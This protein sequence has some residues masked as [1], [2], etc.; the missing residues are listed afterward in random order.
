MNFFISLLLLLVP[1][2][3]YAQI[4]LQ[5]DLKWSEQPVVYNDA[6]GN[7]QWKMWTCS[8]AYHDIDTPTL[9]YLSRQVKVPND[10]QLSVRVI[11]ANFTPFDKEAHEDDAAI[12]EKLQFETAVVRERNKSYGIISFIP[13]IQKGT[14]YERLDSYEIEVSWT[15]SPSTFAKNGNEPTR[16]SVLSVGTLH[17]IAVSETGVYQ[18]S[19]DFLKNELSM[20]IDNIDPRS[21]QIFGNGGGML[22]ERNDRARTDDLLENAIQVVGEEDGQFNEDD[23]ILFFGES[24]D[25]WTYQDYNERFKRAEHYYDTRNYYFIRT[26]V[27]NGKRIAT[28]PSLDGTTYT[29]DAFDDYAFYEK[30]E[31]NLM[32]AASSVQGT[33]R[34]WFSDYF[35]NTKERSYTFEFPNRITS[36]PIHVTA[37]MAGRSSRS[38][39]TYFGIDVA[40]APRMVSVKMNGSNL[41]KPSETRYASLGS[42]SQKANATGEDIIL[43]LHYPTT[44]SGTASTVSAEGWLNYIEVS[45]R[46]RLIMVGNQMMFRDLRAANH[47]RTTF[48]LTGN[49]L[50][51]WDITDAQTV[52]LQQTETTANLIQFGAATDTT[53]QQPIRNFIAFDNNFLTADPIGRIDNQ[54]V[55][56]LDDIDLLVVYH[57]DFTEAV[58]LLRD[59]RSNHSNMDIALV[60][61]EQVY[62]E[63][64]SGK[65]DP[66]AIRDFAKMLLDRNEKF[67]Y[68]LLF[69]DGSFDYKNI[70]EGTNSNF[71]PPYETI[72]S[73]HPING[74]P[75]DDF[76]GLLSE[77]EGTPTLLG[78]L[79][80]GIGRLPVKTA[81]EAFNV[82][83]KIIHYDTSP[84]TLGDW[85]LRMGWVADDEDNNAHIR[86]TENIAYTSDTLYPYFN[87][88]KIYLDAFEQVSS[89]GGQSYPSV[90]E[91]I[92][93]NIFR[94][95]LAINYLGHGGSGG[96]AQERVL[97]ANRGDI[98]N[99]SNYDKLPLFITATCSFSGYDDRNQVTAGEQVLLQARGGGIGLLTTVRAVFASSNARLVGNVMQHLFRKVDGKIP[100][101]GDIARTA[102]NTSNSQS[103]NNRRFTFLGDPS[104]QLAL[105]QHEIVTTSINEVTVTNSSTDTLRA[106]QKLTIAGEIRDSDGR[107]L[108]NFNGTL[109]PTL[110]DKSVTLQTLRN[111]SGSQT[112][113]FDLQKNVIFKGRASVNN[114]KWQFTFVVPRDINYEFGLGKISYYAHDGI[115]Q[116]A[117]G[118]YEQIVVGGTDS[119]ALADDEGPRIEIFMDSEQFIFGGTTSADP[120]LLVQLSDDNGINVA[121]NSIGHDLESTL[122][123]NTQNTIRLNDFYES[124]L[125]DYTKGEVRYQLNDLSDGLHNIKVRAWDVANNP[126]EAYTEFL[127]ASSA[128]VA[129]RNVLNYPNPF[130]DQT[131]FQFDHSLVGQEM[132]VLVQIFTVG[133]RLVK[134]LSTTMLNDGAVRQAD[135]VQW[136]GLDDFGD[137]LGRGVYLYQVKV[138]AIGANAERTGRSGFEKLVILK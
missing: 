83:N 87:Q 114:G 123:N 39:A 36:D 51:I 127:V 107:L 20:D 56:G 112:K 12:T 8:E 101:M 19:Y 96:W 57:P 115:S 31:I 120:L 82:V 88:E 66:T 16:N 73:L 81:Q 106:L 63:F 37:Q 108:D 32:D 100:P 41:D 98:R 10:A 65:Q 116:D 102:K 45:A 119:N 103:E 26:G 44:A 33:G 46:R 5:Q 99:W 48:Q 133:G 124:A 85:R 135:C 59:H 42:L 28:Q 52:R 35:K 104:M 71:V 2:M 18:L 69:G 34:L 17:K 134:T 93:D 64:S 138:S 6:D 91:A 43:D 25:Q 110:Y 109:F 95:M 50:T 79:D 67:K 131:C 15:I 80:I 21:I 137:K 90:T 105:P 55:H 132:E 122:D 1:L 22:P 125:D 61:I 24:P 86:D 113:D 14:T 129:L 3:T 126:S 76:Y 74:Y 4:R 70:K 9:P 121:G 40:G 11:Q 23:Y 78:A 72:E 7:E 136:N 54:N 47:L 75:S 111:D 84:N 77:N 27:S 128:E 58:E 92:N 13:I 68:L 60:S 38:S 118:S 30:E 97:D 29:S 117:L 130:T 62:N 49:N 53:G 94:G 89:S